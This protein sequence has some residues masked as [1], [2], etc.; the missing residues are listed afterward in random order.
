MMLLVLMLSCAG[1]AI[2]LICAGLFS[3]FHDMWVH[4]DHRI[5]EERSSWRNPKPR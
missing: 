2:F 1:G 5:S 4:P 3:E